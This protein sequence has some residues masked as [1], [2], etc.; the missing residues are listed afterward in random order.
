MEHNREDAIKALKVAQ[1]ALASDDPTK[2]LR[3][4]RKACAL[5]WSPEAAALVRQ[6]ENGEGSSSAGGAAP[7]AGMNGSASGMNGSANATTS[8]AQPKAG[9]SA[10]A[11]LRSRTAATASSSSSSP[12]AD[13]KKREWT[14]KQA[15]VVKRVRKCKVT[16]YYEILELKRDCEEVH[17][18]SAYRK[19]RSLASTFRSATKS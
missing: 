4:A 11:G 15:E 12:A 18:K 17:V 3:F 16:E 6:L 7:A 19:V 2:A 9:T 13:D 10:G 1:A 14:P 5:Y 8:G